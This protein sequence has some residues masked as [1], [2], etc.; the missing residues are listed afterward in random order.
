MNFK[1]KTDHWPSQEQAEEL[2]KELRRKIAC[3]DVACSWQL[4]ALDR[5]IVLS[6]MDPLHFH[7]LWI[8]PLLDAGVSVEA[9]TGC[10]VQSYLQPN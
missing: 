2:R 8:M 9:V 5:L 4:E 7:K 1:E 10:I 6:Q 3:E